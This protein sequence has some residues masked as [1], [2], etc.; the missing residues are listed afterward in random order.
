MGENEHMVITR[1]SEKVNNKLT[2]KNVLILLVLCSHCGQKLSIAACTKGT[3]C[4][5]AEISSS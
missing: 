4:M 1:D 3:M 5:K 2:V